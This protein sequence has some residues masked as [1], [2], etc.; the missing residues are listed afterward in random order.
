VGYGDCVPASNLEHA[1]SFFFVFVGTTAFYL[2]DSYESV[3]AEN[4]NEG[5][6]AWSL[7][8][9]AVN[10]FITSREISKSTAK[11]IDRYNKYIFQTQ[12]GFSNSGQSLY[13]LIAYLS[14]GVC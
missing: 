12:K 5:N 6:V 14:I 4:K 2:V 13:Y 3:N 11:Q 1:L 9:R 7:K 10:K 8:M